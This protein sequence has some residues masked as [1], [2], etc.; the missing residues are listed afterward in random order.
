MRPDEGKNKA[1]TV[2]KEFE[3]HTIR[4]GDQSHALEVSPGSALLKLTISV[5]VTTCPPVGFEESERTFDASWN[6]RE[7]AR[8]VVDARG[9]ICMGWGGPVN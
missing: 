4:F 2:I 3:T 7:I 5:R 1:L 9:T 8:A 6:F